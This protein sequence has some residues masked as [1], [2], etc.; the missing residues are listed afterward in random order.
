MVPDAYL[1]T[2]LE[3]LRAAQNPDGGWGYFPGKESWLEPTAYAAMALHG[4][5][6]S[7]G[8][9]AV[10][11]VMSN[12]ATTAFAG[13]RMDAR[14]REV[15][16]PL[17]ARVMDPAQARLASADGYMSHTLMHEIC[18]GL[19]PAYARRDG[20]QVDIREAIGPAFSGLEEAKADVVGMFSLQ[21]LV[22]HDVLPRERLAEY[23]LS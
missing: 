21:W 22:D 20:R 5:A 18:H 3:A 12:A 8:V 9:A 23:Y 7:A 10:D 13:R 16:L 17:A 6:A 14:V 11:A 2:R 1:N 19:G 4:D 15:I